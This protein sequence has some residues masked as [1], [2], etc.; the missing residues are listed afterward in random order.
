MQPTTT[1]PTQ[2]RLPIDTGPSDW[3]LDERTR[4]IGRRGLAEARAALAQATRLAHQR[5]AERR[6]A[7]RHAAA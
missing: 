3:R 5:D 6:A 4:E 2:E 7:D 1:T